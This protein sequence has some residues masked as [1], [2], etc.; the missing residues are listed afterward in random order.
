MYF[1]RILLE[2]DKWKI[3]PNRKP[4]ILR[5]ARQ[6]GKTTAVRLFGEGYEQFIYLNLENYEDA[7]LFHKSNG[8]QNLVEAIFFHH[9]KSL[10]KRTNTLL[11]IDEIQAVPKAIA[12]L[13]YFYED[14]PELHVIAAGSLLE[15]VLK[16]NVSIPVGRV[17]YKILHPVSFDEFLT[18][19]NES[20]AA[21]LLKQIPIKEYS[22]EKILQLFHTYSL[23]GGMPEVVQHYAE[24][25]DLNSLTPIYES[26]LVS[27][28]EDVEKYARNTSLT[29]VIRH[30]IRA[31][32]T[33]AGSRIAFH[34]FGQSN[35]K[36]REVGEALRT[37]EKTLL[38]RL[39]YPV[40]QTQLPLLP[41]KRKKPRLQVL[42]TGLMNRF[43]G[44]QASLLG[45]ASLNNLY[46]GKVVEHIVGQEL[47][48]RKSNIL[49]EIYFWVREKKDA[50]AEVD[51][52]VAFEDKI[53][54]LEV[55]S[56]AVGRLKSLHQFMERVPHNLAIRLYSGK[57][58]FH[59]AETP[60]GKKF[61]LLNLPYYLISR[62]DDYL[63]WFQKQISSD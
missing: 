42:D 33:E 22:H 58:N 6:V 5:G 37:L 30:C 62:L 21:D 57:L 20:M 44:L 48:A 51:F 1:R 10:Q 56:G 9:S 45:I 53:I 13:R 18:A 52:V 47:L 63:Y 39:V 41:D 54:P 61:H 24:H 11:F 59:A 19:M 26:I 49:N 34:G 8:I 7:S 23:I 46:E 3:S 50:E 4:L 38:I 14:L 43:A 25:R 29:Q 32:Y 17:E 40:T 35:Y 31:A 16:E 60:N 15:T 55:K 28:L 2:L 12:W 27:Y 36:S